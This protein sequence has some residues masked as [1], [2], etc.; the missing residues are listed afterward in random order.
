MFDG[1]LYLVDYLEAAG[2]GHLGVGSNSDEVSIGGE[3]TKVGG[4]GVFAKAPVA[5]EVVGGREF[6]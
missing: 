4:G 6:L 5:G 1:S 2:A 3:A